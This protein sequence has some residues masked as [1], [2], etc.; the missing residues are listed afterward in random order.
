MMN[1]MENMMSMMG[2]GGG[3]GGGMPGG[4]NPAMMQAAMAQVQQGGM[5]LRKD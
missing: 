4:L 3:G 5:I 2:G 1:M